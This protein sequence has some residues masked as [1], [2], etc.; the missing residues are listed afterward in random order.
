MCQTSVYPSTLTKYYWIQ[1]HRLQN[2]KMGNFNTALSPIG[3][4]SRQKKKI[5][6]ETS[7]LIDTINQMELTKIYRVF[8][9]IIHNIHSPQ[10]PFSKIGHILRHRTSF[11]K[12]KKVE[13]TFCILSVHN[14]IKLEIKSKRNYRKY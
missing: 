3:M 4:S 1:K 10:Q 9:P 7:E 12:C 6:K 2:N 14:G 13:L 11:S 8:H 5:N